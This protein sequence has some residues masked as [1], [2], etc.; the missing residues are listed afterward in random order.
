[1]KLELKNIGRIKK[2]TFEFNGL[3]IIVGD[4]NAGKSTVGKALAT[5]FTVLPTLGERILNTRRDYVFDSE[6]LQYAY[7]F[8][9]I[10]RE[11][12]RNYFE[13][14][15]LTESTLRAHMEKAWGES[16][17]WLEDD[18]TGSAQ[19]TDSERMQVEGDAQRAF[20]R[21]V[22][23][24][25]IPYGR[26]VNLEIGKCFSYYFHGAARRVGSE[27]SCIN[28]TIQGQ[29]DKIILGEH[30]EC[31][32]PITL[33]NHGWFIGSPLI[34]NAVKGGYYR[35]SDPERMHFPLLRRLNEVRDVNS[36]ARALV[37]E[38]LFPIESR[39]EKLL[40]GRVYFSEQD[41]ILKIRGNAYPKPLPIASLSMGLKAFAVLRWMLEVGA[42]QEQDVLVLDEPENHLHPQW[43]IIYAEIIV[44]LQDC[45]RLTVLLTTHSPY[46]LEA[47]QLYARRYRVE[48]RVTAYQPE[49]DADG[50]SVTFSANITDTAEL[51]RKF[52]A[53]LRVLDVL[54]AEMSSE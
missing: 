28:L 41:G 23:C 38:K 11:S 14:Q 4:N 53:P 33:N 39:L 22:E 2:A 7:R 52:T 44:L 31:S 9:S 30:T 47:I 13:D 25:R 6:A 32:L 24:R 42:L 18:E 35:G 51:Y 5:L 29:T 16:K 37:A 26:L 21:L 3:T 54:R 34:I 46:F 49:M 17:Q 27:A 45:F 20:L 15:S 12:F 8:R 43:Q 1:M 10:G 19:L 40:G 48:D 50:L 36:V